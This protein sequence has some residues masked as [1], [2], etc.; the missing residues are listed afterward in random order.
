MSPGTPLLAVTGV[1]EFERVALQEVGVGRAMAAMTGL[2]S[3][4]YGRVLPPR[5]GVCLL[6]VAGKTERV[7]DSLGLPWLVTGLARF[8]FP[9][10][11]DGLLLHPGGE[12]PD[13]S[14]KGQAEQ[15]GGKRPKMETM[16][17]ENSAVPPVQF[18]AAGGSGSSA[19]GRRGRGLGKAL[20]LLQTV[21]RWSRAD[22]NP[23]GPY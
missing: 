8:V 22:Q 1:T 17:S 13:H 7:C 15:R 11:M 12:D 3:A 23:G 10:G 2:A 6:V 20:G 4:L 21:L 16:K 9:G 19:P 5:P 18:R 14:E